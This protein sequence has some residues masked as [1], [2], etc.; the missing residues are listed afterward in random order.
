MAFN[1]ALVGYGGRLWVC[2]ITLRDYL[3]TNPDAVRQYVGVKKSFRERGSL[4]AGVLAYK[5]PMITRLIDQAIAAS[6]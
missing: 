2:N 3:R 4:A 5:S 1:I 6:L